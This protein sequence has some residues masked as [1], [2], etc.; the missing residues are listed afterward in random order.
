MFVVVLEAA[1]VMCEIPFDKYHGAGNDFIIVDN[2]RGCMDIVISDGSLVKSMCQ[3]RY[4]IGADGMLIICSPDNCSPGDCS[5]GDCSHGDYDFEL[6]YYNSD[7]L[8]DTLCG[9]GM[10]C[11][12]M[13]VII[14]NIIRKKHTTF[15][16][17]DGEH[18]GFM[19]E[20]GRIHV[21]IKNINS[22]S[23]PPNI[24]YNDYVPM[25]E[26]NLFINNGVPHHVMVVNDVNNIDV[27]SIG[28]QFQKDDR[29]I[30]TRGTNVMFVE[31]INSQEYKV[32]SFERGVN[33]ETLACGTGAIACVMALEYLCSLQGN[34]IQSS[35]QKHKLCH[36]PGGTLEVL[37][38]FTCPS[39]FTEVYLTGPVQHIYTGKYLQLKT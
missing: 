7:G 2:T 6:K 11:A 27:N 15:L 39:H 36:F 5:P 24:E 20:N 34:Y 38:T 25:A 26:H 14:Q 13:Y 21:N 4:G 23:K 33:D 22:L 29:F 32:R 18:K 1:G 16:T 19:D 3:R 10:R 17:C 35:G 8:G 30:T 37:Y 9:N 12:V 28:K 31:V